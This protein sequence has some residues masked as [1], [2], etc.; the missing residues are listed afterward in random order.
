M[1]VSVSSGT[2]GVGS[3]VRDSKKNHKN[4]YI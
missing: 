2:V 4:D 1:E 3:I